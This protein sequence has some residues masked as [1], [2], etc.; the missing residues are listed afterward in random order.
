MKRL[1]QRAHLAALGTLL[2]MAALPACAA[3]HAAGTPKPL[4]Q[5]QVDGLV[6]GGVA[7]ERLI[8]LVKHRGISFSVTPGFLKALKEDGADRAFIDELERL[9]PRGLPSKDVVNPAGRKAQQY[10]AQGK[11][12]LDQ[13]QYAKAVAQLQSAERLNPLDPDTH[14]YLARAL[15]ATGKLD[16]AVSQYRQTILLSPDTTPARFNLGNLLLRQR[17]WDPAAAQFRVALKLSPGDAG[18]YYGLGIALYREGKYS[19]ASAEYRKSLAIAPYDER[20][21]L[22]LGLALQAQNDTDGAISQYRTALKL[23][24]RDAMAH[25]DLASALVKKG[26]ENEAVSELRAAMKLAPQDVS[27]HASYN[28]LLKQARTDPAPRH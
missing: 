19:A 2:L 9:A 7:S 27:Y 26:L 14:F 12:Y 25:A 22:A 11:R 15:A 1:V 3:V 8:S 6:R 24:P 5:R 10:R 16:Q 4:D 23:A 20:V 18:A 21:H 17:K 28:A 13:R